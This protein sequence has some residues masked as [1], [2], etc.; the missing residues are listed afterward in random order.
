MLKDKLIDTEK[1][2]INYY[3]YVI[4]DSDFSVLIGKKSSYFTCHHSK[5]SDE[6]VSTFLQFYSDSLLIVCYPKK[7]IE[8][9]PELEKFI[10]S[11]DCDTP[12]NIKI[13]GDSIII[14]EG[15]I[16]SSWRI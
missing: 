12:V 15:I 13:S 16:K 4:Q 1:N 11:P 5:L 10:F 2:R 7:V 6:I 9:Y 14:S 3:H 8:K